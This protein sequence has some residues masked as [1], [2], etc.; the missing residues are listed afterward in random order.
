MAGSRINLICLG[1]NERF[2]LQTV[3]ISLILLPFREEASKCPALRLEQVFYFDLCLPVV[4]LQLDWLTLWVGEEGLVR[5][6]PR[7]EQSNHYEDQ[8]YREADARPHGLI[9]VGCPVLDLLEDAGLVLYLVPHVLGVLQEVTSF[10]PFA[11][12]LCTG[13]R[14]CLHS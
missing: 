6:H 14:W 7:L 9:A 11:R 5:P 12:A 13:G 3:W 10:V 4:L 8:Q 2:H 1:V